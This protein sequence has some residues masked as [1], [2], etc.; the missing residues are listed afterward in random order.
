MLWTKVSIAFAVELLKLPEFFFECHLCEECIDAL[1]DV[2]RAL[3]VRRRN[4]TQDGENEK[5]EKSMF[6][7]RKWIGKRHKS[8]KKVLCFMCLFVVCF[9]N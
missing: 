6:H 3:A 9:R 1:L 8:H 4:N 2:A 5:E 7:V